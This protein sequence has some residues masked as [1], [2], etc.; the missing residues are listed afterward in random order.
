MQSNKRPGND[1]L[2]KGAYK[3]FKEH[4]GKTSIQY[5]FSKES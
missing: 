5:Q 1:G 2:T 4:I 3:T